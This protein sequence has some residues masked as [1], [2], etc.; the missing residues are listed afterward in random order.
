MCFGPGDGEE[1]LRVEGWEMPPGFPVIPLLGSVTH[2]SLSCFFS[3]GKWGIRL[4]LKGTWEKLDES[5]KWVLSA[6]LTL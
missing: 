6:A 3:H 1:L 5:L 2:F 4:E